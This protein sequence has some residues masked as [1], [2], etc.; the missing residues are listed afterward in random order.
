MRER[1]WPAI[2]TLAIV[3][4]AAACGGPVPPSPSGEAS[5]PGSPDAS[6]PPSSGQAGLLLSEVLFAPSGG[7]PAFVEI[8]NTSASSQG[9]A[10]ATLRLSDG[11]FQL[12]DAADLPADGRLVVLFD[13]QDAVDG[14]TIHAPGG[15][16][17]PADQGSVELVD[18]D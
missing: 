11:V 4:F 17:L 7:D 14:S 10:D 3:V 16:D 13:G 12:A 6:A 1:R 18:G 5:A 9:L 2:G 15:I 8:A